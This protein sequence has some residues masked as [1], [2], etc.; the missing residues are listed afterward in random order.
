M[1]GFLRIPRSYSEL[2]EELDVSSWFQFHILI[3]RVR[4]A[5]NA[6]QPVCLIRPALQLFN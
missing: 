4:L 3:T 6:L 1:S 2:V 5:G